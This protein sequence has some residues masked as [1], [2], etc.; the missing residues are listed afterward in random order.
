MG[1]R[2]N[3]R[4]RPR[5]HSAKKPTPGQSSPAGSNLP[6]QPPR[7]HSRAAG[8][9]GWDCRPHSQTALPQAEPRER[10]CACC[11]SSTAAGGL[12]F[13]SSDSPGTLLRSRRKGLRGGPG[14]IDR[15]AQGLEF[16]PSLRDQT[17]DGGIR[18]LSECAPGG[19]YSYQPP[20]EHGLP[21]SE[22]V[23]SPNDFRDECCHMPILLF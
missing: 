23:D 1:R 12:P 22:G 11:G 8:Q 17:A 5:T 9:L 3:S 14:L 6:Q 21:L 19:L 13:G 2:P 4:A 20:C 16:Q 7:P 10:G 15:A 18:L